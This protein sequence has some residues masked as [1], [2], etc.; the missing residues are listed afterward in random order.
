MEKRRK[1][2]NEEAKEREYDSSARIIIFAKILSFSPFFDFFSFPAVSSSGMFVKMESREF[3]LMPREREREGRAR[4]DWRR[5]KIRLI[6]L[7]VRL[8]AKWARDYFHDWL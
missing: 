3:H 6:T 8:S 5:R 1:K 7:N 4:N 2:G